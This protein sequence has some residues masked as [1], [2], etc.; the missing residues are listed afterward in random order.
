MN[1]I[2]HRV[3]DDKCYG[4]KNRGGG[5]R[6]VSVSEGMVTGLATMARKVTLRR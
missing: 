3:D 2:Y 1:K 5:K 6:R 4:E